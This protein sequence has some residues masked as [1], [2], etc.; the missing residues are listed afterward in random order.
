[1]ATT[2]SWFAQ[3]PFQSMQE[4]YF[5][6]AIRKALSLWEASCDVAFVRAKVG[7]TVHIYFQQGPNYPPPA[8]LGYVA[9]IGLWPCNIVLFPTDRWTVAKRDPS[10]NEMDA[11][12]VI[13]HEVGHALLGPNH[14]P[15]GNLMAE[16]YHTMAR[17]PQEADIR[18]AIEKYGPPPERDPHAHRVLEYAI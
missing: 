10:W 4:D 14:L 6:A 12:R 16:D 11:V 3:G 8:E 5:L 7:E 13:A 17:L 1:M 18:L 2:L 9:N 15:A